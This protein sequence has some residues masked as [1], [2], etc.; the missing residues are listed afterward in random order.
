MYP[1]GNLF[2]PTTHGRIEAILK[3]PD[4]RFSPQTGAALI[5]H[6]H[7]QFGGTMHNKVVFRTARA[8]NECGILTLRFNYRGVGLSTGIFGEGEGEME[9]ARACLDYLAQK[10]PNFSIML[11]GFSFGARY[12]LEVGINDSRVIRLIGIG[13]PVDKYDFDFL[14]SCRKPILFVQGERDEFGSTE[15]LIELTSTLPPEANAQVE[16]IQSTGHFFEGKLD[17]LVKAIK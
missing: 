14:K 12:G 15:K 13:T 11:A 1:Q 6:P 9:D 5:L 16:I 8:L 3:E 2:I 10:Y 7:P 4:K 17:E